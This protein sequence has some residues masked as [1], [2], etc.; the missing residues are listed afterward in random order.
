[1][2]QE[3]DDPN[4]ALEVGGKDEF[5]ALQMAIIHLETFVRRLTSDDAGKLF[6]QDGTPFEMKDMNLLSYFLAKSMASQ[7][8][9]RS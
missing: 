1:M 8:G 2:V 6:N 4:L 9:Q 5:E 7:E 3:T